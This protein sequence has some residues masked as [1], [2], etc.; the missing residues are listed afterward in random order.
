[1]HGGHVGP[2]VDPVGQQDEGNG[3]SGFG[4]FIWATKPEDENESNVT[5]KNLNKDLF[6][7]YCF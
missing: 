2:Q 4:G 1:M 6:K 7:I 5:I 3:Q